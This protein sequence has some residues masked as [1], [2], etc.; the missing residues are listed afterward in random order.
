[1]LALDE[2]TFDLRQEVLR[3]HEVEQAQ[4]CQPQHQIGEGDRVQRRRVDEDALLSLNTWS[5]Q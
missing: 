1:M 4:L 3:P 5:A 2:D